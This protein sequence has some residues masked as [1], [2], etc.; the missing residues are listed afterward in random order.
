[1]ASIIELVPSTS[2]LDVT[3][4]DGVVSRYPWLWLRDHSHDPETLHPVSRQRLLFTA[5]VPADISASRAAVEGDTLVVEWA[6]GSSSQL[7]VAFLAGLREP[8][9][10]PTRVEVEP[11]LWDSS[12]IYPTPG[13]PY[14]EIMAS[15]EGTIRWLTEVARYGFAF[16]TGT[17]A[18]REA[19]E[20]LLHRVAY[21][22]QSI[23]GGFWEFTADMKHAD[24][25]YTNTELLAHTD[26]TYSHDAPGLQLLHCLEFLDP[27]GGD[28]TMVDGFRIAQELKD[29]SPDYYELLSSFSI[30]AQYIGDGAHL[31]SARPALRHDHTGRLVQVSLNN[32]DRAPFL[33]PAEEM[34]AFY[35]ALRAVEELANDE[36]LQWQ[37]VL[38]PGEAMLFD[39][40]R[41]LHGRK[42]YSGTRTLCGAYLNH[43]DFE[44]RLR[45]GH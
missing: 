12:T 24:L 36:R 17:P 31:M 33:L 42:A 39:N 30:P 1:M 38:A 5:G 44:S 32:G 13:V 9:P 29:K 8:A 34:I 28:S 11:V 27:V 7:P 41:V 19:T 35:D 14:D 25:A 45:M 43:E 23:F 18:T 3:W 15:D 4:D 26:G 22:R 40:W 37:H 6:D 20:A 21:V 16:A 10:V 2:I